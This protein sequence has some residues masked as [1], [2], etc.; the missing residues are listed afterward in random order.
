MRRNG[1]F[2]R[3]ALNITLNLARDDTLRNSESR[4]PASEV[5]HKPHFTPYHFLNIYIY[6]YNI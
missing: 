6:I 4:L 3:A 1:R 5:S 2:E